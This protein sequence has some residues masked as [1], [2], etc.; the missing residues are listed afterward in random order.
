MR[1]E[2]PDRNAEANRDLFEAAAVLKNIK[3]NC[4]LNQSTF[5]HLI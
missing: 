5:Y 3:I 2:H 1:Q 4:Q